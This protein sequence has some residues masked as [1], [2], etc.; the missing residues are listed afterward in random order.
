M[1][2]KLAT[3]R[4]MAVSYD[5]VP[6]QDLGVLAPADL[7]ALLSRLQLNVSGNIPSYV[8]CWGGIGR[9]GTVTGC[10]LVE[11]GGLD[12]SQALTCIADLRRGTPDGHRR[13]PETDEQRAM[14]LGWADLRQD[15]VQPRSGGR[16]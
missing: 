10:W 13:S 14:V 2:K 11:H 5:R 3:G 7:G 1:L 16:R 8:H 12:G 4:E 9:T 6:M 15:V